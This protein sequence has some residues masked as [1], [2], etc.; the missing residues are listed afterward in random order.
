MTSK[1]DLNE[2]NE[3]FR[4]LPIAMA[5]EVGN[6]NGL[7]TEYCPSGGFG[8]SFC[9]SPHSKGPLYLLG[10][11]PIIRITSSDLLC[12]YVFPVSV[13]LPSVFFS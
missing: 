2:E 3:K 11:G 9:S 5:L 7:V 13:W 6:Y 12:L 4:G 8:E 1:I 10:H